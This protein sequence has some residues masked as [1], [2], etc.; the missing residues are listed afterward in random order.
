MNT[1]IRS[2]ALGLCVVAVVLLSLLFSVSL[3]G[4]AVSATL[5]G[6]V[7]D[8]SGA[9]VANAKVTL[10][11]S[12]TNVSRTT[13]T[14]ESGNFVFPD[15]PP[16]NYTV[17][18]EMTGFKK[19]ERRDIALLVNT[20]QR[21]DIKITPGNITETV[22]VTRRSAGVADGPPPIPAATS[23][24]WWCRNCRVHREQPQLSS[25]AGAGAWHLAAHRGRTPG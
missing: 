10:T 4:Q 23:T 1:R 3:F 24:R 25:V 22:E 7:S 5:L 14:N 11:E 21:V 15:V 17:A 16:G 19:E 9:S 18:V 20:A 6:S 13:Q 8:V 12:N 2:N